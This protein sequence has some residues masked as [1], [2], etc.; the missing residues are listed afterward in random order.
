M[1]ERIERNWKPYTLL[2]WMQNGAAAM[3]NSVEVPKKWKVEPP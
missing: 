2:M 1:L 3:E